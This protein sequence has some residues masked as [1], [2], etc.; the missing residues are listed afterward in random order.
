MMRKL[1]KASSLMAL[2]LMALP[3]RAQLVNA[4]KAVVDEAVITLLDVERQTLQ[5][6]DELR[7]QY[8]N[9]EALLRRKLDQSAEEN[10]ERLVDRKLVLKDFTAAG[11]SLPESLVDD[12]VRDRIKARFGDRA[13]ATKTLQAQGIT[14]EKFRQ[15]V[16]ETFIIDALRAKHVSSEIIISPHKVEVYYAAHTNDFQ[17]EEQV[18]LRLIQINKSDDPKAPVADE[19]AREI[20]S[21]IKE[22]AVFAD[23][24]KL[25]S[26][27]YTKADGGDYPWTTRQGLR[28]EI[29]EVAFRLK[30]GETSD[31]I[32]TPDACYLIQLQEVRPAHTKPL[33]EVR[34]DIERALRAE[35]QG[36][37]EKQ[38]VNRLRQKTFVRYF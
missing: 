15:Q 12:L 16:R 26:Q 21:K 24:A 22:G 9:D 28:K 25:Y 10:L 7:R 31:V 14:Y 3:C 30:P 33:A 11:Y 36:R 13:T 8:R 35:E 2:V 5:T 17:V 20:L 1:F 4:I 29:T 23:L 27:S 18:K 32:D 6:A 37:L 38:W 34:D 19:L